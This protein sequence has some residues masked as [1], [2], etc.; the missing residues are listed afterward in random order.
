MAPEAPGGRRAT[1]YLLCASSR[2]RDCRR[3]GLNFWAEERRRSH[4]CSSHAW[5]GYQEEANSRHPQ[6]QARGSEYW[7]RGIVFYGVELNQSS[8]NF[9]AGGPVA[10]ET[11]ANSARCQTLCVCVCVCV[12]LCAR[13]RVSSE[14][15]KL[16]R[17]SRVAPRVVCTQMFL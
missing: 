8:I 13:V 4:I 1:A 7:G 16:R 2:R 5:L 3:T 14:R 17:V 9:T 12:C 15:A 11:W 6:D 10:L